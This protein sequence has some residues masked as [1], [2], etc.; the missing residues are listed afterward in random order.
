MTQACKPRRR[1]GTN[2]ETAV[3]VGAR[4]KQPKRYTAQRKASP[5]RRHTTRKPR[6]ELGTNAG[7]NP[8]RT[9]RR[10]R[11]FDTHSLSLAR[12]HASPGHLPREAPKTTGRWAEA[13]NE[14]LFHA[15]TASQRVRAQRGKPR[16]QA[17]EAKS[18]RGKAHLDQPPRC[19]GG[20]D[21]QAS[22]SLAE[23]VP[24]GDDANRLPQA[25][26]GHFAHAADLRT[27][28]WGGME[29]RAQTPSCGRT[30]AC[31]AVWC[32][33]SAPVPCVARNFAREKAAD[34][35]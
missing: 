28:G 6:N 5:V 7:K 29:R 1:G 27:G 2:G 26:L 9:V 32:L 12:A 3:T 10:K 18:Q 13:K 21:V 15:C 35:R 19:V 17:K 33:L 31:V 20:H 16:R 4:E 30:H 8:S 24:A 22:S 25:F 34:G 23:Q 11:A 14:S